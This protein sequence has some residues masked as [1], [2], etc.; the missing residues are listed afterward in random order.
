MLYLNH[1][2]II[3]LQFGHRILILKKDCLSYKKSNKAFVS[4]KK[5]RK[6]IL[7]LSLRVAIF[8]SSMIILHLKTPF[9]YVNP[10]NINFLNHLITGVDFPLSFIPTNTRWSN[11]GCLNIT[12]HRKYGR[13]SVCVSAIKLILQVNHKVLEKATNTLFFEIIYLT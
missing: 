10:L 5:R 2:Y 6:H 8:L 9:L 3:L 1:I 12:S 13:N 4:L 11:L 7:T